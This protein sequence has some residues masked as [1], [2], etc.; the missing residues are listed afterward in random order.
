MKAKIILLLTNCI[1]TF[2]LCV[3]Y[4]IYKTSKGEITSETKKN[5]D[6]SDDEKVVVKLKK[7]LPE[8]I[9]E[10][11]KIKKVPYKL[12]TDLPKSVD[13]KKVLKDNI[14]KIWNI[15]DGKTSIEEV[16]KKSGA[17]EKTAKRIF[18][19]LNKVKLVEIK[20][21]KLSKQRQ[22]AEDVILI[23]PHLYKGVQ[24]IRSK[25]NVSLDRL[26]AALDFL[27][28]KKLIEFKPKSKVS[29]SKKDDFSPEE[30]DKHLEKLQLDMKG[31]KAKEKKVEPKKPIS[32]FE[33]SKG[34]KDQKEPKSKEKAKPEIDKEDLEKRLKR[35][36]DDSYKLEPGGIRPKKIKEEEP[37]KEEK[38]LKQK[39]EEK[40]EI[41]S[42][43]KPKVEEEPKK[44]VSKKEVKIAKEKLEK[45][46]NKLRKAKTEA[47]TAQAEKKI[48]D[49]IYKELDEAIDSGADQKQVASVIESIKGELFDFS[50]SVK[51]DQSKVTDQL[52]AALFAILHKL[53]ENSKRLESIATLGDKKV[54]LFTKKVYDN[55]TKRKKQET[56]EIEKYLDYLKKKKTEEGD[57]LISF[58]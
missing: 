31:E 42:I 28:S 30:I 32:L 4:N 37:K 22:I 39:E 38:K 34:I 45:E 17:K 55:D 58:E 33:L 29:K 18:D 26:K 25:T 1:T 27:K 57:D 21:N 44:E 7:E 36:R 10:F 2:N 19:F 14:R 5:N 23:W 56:K 41:K 6:S 46:M 52:T 9:K 20:T 54:G 48:V 24:K 35:L 49:S 15:I 12:K 11:A 13:E 51:Q 43:E 40:K 8:Y 53:E 3:S 47:E 16:I 50:R